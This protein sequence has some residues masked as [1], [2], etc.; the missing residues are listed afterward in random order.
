MAHISGLI[1]GGAHAS[2][3][4]HAQIVT[5][6]THKTLRGPRGALILATEEYA[7]AVDKAVFPRTQGGPFMHVIAAKAVAFGEALRPGFA[8]YA[9]KIVE[10]SRALAKVLSNGGMRLVSG[11]T[12][13]HLI[14]VDLTPLGITGRKAEEALGE[15]KI[16]VNRNAI[17]YDPRPPRVTSG[18]RIGT[19]A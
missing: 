17:P 10:N 5:A 15:M 1:A 2:P 14:L 4:P 3:R 12:D 8:L 11:G 9:E 16:Y 6:T 13:N 18:L 19:A 7:K